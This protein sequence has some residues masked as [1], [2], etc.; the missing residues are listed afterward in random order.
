MSQKIVV[1][2]TQ[3]DTNGIGYEVII[4]ALSDNRMLDLCTPVI[5]GSS[6]AFGFYRKGIPETDNI[7]TNVVASAANAHPRRVNIVNCVPDNGPI[8][9][10]QCTHDGAMGAITALGT[11]VEDLKKGDI[12]VLVTAPF[13]KRAVTLETFKYAG[14]TEYLTKEFDAKEGLMFLCS[15]TIRVGV[16]TGHVALTKVPDII[17]EDLILRKLRVMNESL[18]RDFNI[19][20]PKIAVLGLNP[21]SGDRGLLGDEEINVISPAIVK[22]NEEGILAFGPYPPD[23]FFSVNMQYKFD[24]VLAMYHD[25]GLI[26]FKALAF[27][28]GVKEFDEI[29]DATGKYILPGVIDDQVHFREPGLTRKADMESESMA[30]VAGGTT[31]FMDMPNT[32]PQTITEAL[33]KEKRDIAASKAVANYAFY[34]GATNENIEELKKVD[35]SLIC[36]VKVFM[37]SSTGNMLVDNRKIL[38]R[39]FSELSLIVATHCEKEE[40]IKA[41][42][43]KYVSQYGEDLSIDFHS[44]IRNEDACY[45]SSS[46]AVE[47]AT[48]MGGKLHML[49]LST[50]KEMSLLENKPL[51]DKKITSEVCVHHLWFNDSDYATYGNKIKWNP[52]IKSENDRL[53]LMEAVNNGKLDIIAT[54]HAPHLWEEKQGSCLKA[55]SGGPIIQYSLLIMLEKVRQGEISIEKVVEKMS[56]AHTKFTFSHNPSPWQPEKNALTCIPHMALN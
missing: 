55:A 54:D 23:G 7:N 31:T 32:N 48:K 4:K 13:N 11:A 34:I 16:V 15:D 33:I 2:I 9:P 25:Q 36:G 29:I 8:E 50:A 39:I 20:K 18:L 6:R 5:Y 42:I 45:A 19:V 52:A 27:D 37:G 53:A 14:H 24:A 12:D 1:G 26:P 49:H 10:G 38:E 56:H 47:L 40:V 21:H 51:K 46:E 3:G 41:N 35:N 28:S 43:A 30:A 22:A 17:T 44:K